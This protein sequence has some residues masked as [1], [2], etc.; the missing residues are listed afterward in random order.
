MIGY[1]GA[2]SSF[3][4]KLCSTQ[5][6]NKFLKKGSERKQTRADVKEVKAVAWDKVIAFMNE[7]Q[8]AEAQNG[9]D[10]YELEDRYLEYLCKYGVFMGKHVTRFG[11]EMLERA[12]NYEIIKD[13]ET[14]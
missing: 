5:L 2:N 13:G 14:P 4:Y 10:I 12:S 11:H 6:Y 1:L 3:Y 9:F 8:E 7:T